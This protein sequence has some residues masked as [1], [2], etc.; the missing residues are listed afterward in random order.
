MRTLLKLFCIVVVITSKKWL[1]FLQLPSRLVTN[2]LVPFLFLCRYVALHPVLWNKK[3]VC[4]EELE[5]H[6]GLTNGSRFTADLANVVDPIW[7][8]LTG[9]LNR[10]HWVE[11][12][13]DALSPSIEYSVTGSVS[14]T[15][16]VQA[17]KVTGSADG[18]VY[19]KN[20]SSRMHAPK[21]SRYCSC[22]ILIYTVHS[23]MPAI[24][25]LIFDAMLHVLIALTNTPLL[26][27]YTTESL[28]PSS[29]VCS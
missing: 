18:G 16:V 2:L 14:C 7:W 3:V 6:R 17:Q 22:F 13:L 27:V 21:Y 5:L 15:L 24:Y 20:V 28:Q 9:F 8:L 10:M 26:S 29:V 12:H 25:F 19:I 11:P 4:K 1:L 23:L